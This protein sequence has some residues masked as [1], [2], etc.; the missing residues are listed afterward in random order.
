M[1]LK[2]LK[3]KGVSLYLKSQIMTLTENKQKQKVVAF[4]HQGERKELAAEKIILAAGIRPNS[5]LN[6]PAAGV[7]FDEKGIKVN[8]YLESSMAHIQALGDVIGLPSRTPAVNHQARLI[9]HNLAQKRQKNK[10]R[11]NQKCSP[12]T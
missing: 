5:D 10:R 9:I 1:R 3:N 11:F 7:E 12:V 2:F 6:L 4:S 8:S